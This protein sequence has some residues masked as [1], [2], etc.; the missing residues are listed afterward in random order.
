MSP[1]VAVPVCVPSPVRIVSSGAAAVERHCL[2]RSMSP[3]SEGDSCGGGQKT[4]GY[5]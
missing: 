4:F 5:R 2:A 3:P 1:S